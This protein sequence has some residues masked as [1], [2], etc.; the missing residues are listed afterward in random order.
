MT[1][2]PIQP[3]QLV[4]RDGVLIDTANNIAY[5]EPKAPPSPNPNHHRINT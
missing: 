3:E 2:Y 1:T 5:I 4:R